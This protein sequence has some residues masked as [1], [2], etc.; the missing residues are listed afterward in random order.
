MALFVRKRG[1]KGLVD[2]PVTRRNLREFEE[3]GPTCWQDFNYLT[4]RQSERLPGRA[5]TPGTKL[6]INC[7]SVLANSDNQAEIVAEAFEMSLSKA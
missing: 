2:L 4:I 6:P 1:V 5:T 7:H 3:G